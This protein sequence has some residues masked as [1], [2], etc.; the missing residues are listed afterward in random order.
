M[1]TKG[2]NT[3]TLGSMFS[4]IGG[5]DLGFEQAGWETK[6][7]IEIDP[8]N[9]AVLADRFPR[10]DRFEDVRTTRPADLHR[11]DCIAAG[12]P[13]QDIS[14]SGSARKDRSKIG[15][16]GNRSGLFFEIIRYLRALQPTWVVLENV[17][18]LLFVNDRADF[19]TVIRSLA[20]CGYVGFWR[21]LNARYFGVPQARKRIFLVAGLGRYP[22]LE[23]LADAAPVESVSPT[24]FEGGVGGAEGGFAS[25]TLQATSTTSQL[26]LGCEILVAEENGWH[27][28]VE[29]ARATQL[30]GLCAGMAPADLKE[31]FGAGNAVCP[32]VARW[33]AEMLARS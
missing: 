27:Q 14:I 9:R 21:V 32:P 7:Q 3:L 20:E 31:A 33:V 18:A 24:Q 29:R 6:W 12:F 8:I 4:G 2:G 16:A 30:H 11:V 13:C 17:P 19:E 25:F 5:F 28:M 15:L 23:F 10:A 26:A 22:S 1:K